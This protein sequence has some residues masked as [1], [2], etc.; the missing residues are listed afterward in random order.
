MRA[1]TRRSNPREPQRPIVEVTYAPEPQ[2]RDQLVEV[3]LE[4][5]DRK[6]G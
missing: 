5:L 1:R 3:L 4:L 6:A 2:A